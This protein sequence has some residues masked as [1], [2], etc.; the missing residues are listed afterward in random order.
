MNPE[1]RPETPADIAAIHD[2]TA[3]AFL[4][5]PHTAHT[6][7]FV[8]DELRK[9]GALAISLVADDRGVVVGHVAVS[10]VLISDGTAGWFYPMCLR[11]ISWRCH[12]ANRC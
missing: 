12:L 5:A 2:L 8:V 4:H 1:V 7:Q 3:A 6:E 10:P 9:A 11:S